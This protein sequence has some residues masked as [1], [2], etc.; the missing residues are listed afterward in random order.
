MEATDL[1]AA[2]GRAGDTGKTPKYFHSG[3]IGEEWVKSRG[4]RG[5]K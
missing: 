3:D 1:S 4:G 5:P 2:E